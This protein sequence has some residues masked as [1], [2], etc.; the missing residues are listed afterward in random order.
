MHMSLE[1]CERETAIHCDDETKTWSIYTRQ[2]RVITKLKRAGIEPYKIQEDG[3][4]W[5]K[6]IPFERIS[7]RSESKGRNMTEEQRKAA[8]ERLR[9]ARKAKGGE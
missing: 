7:F 5:Y 1:A 8:A 4:H 6:D 9:K 2:Q 3:A